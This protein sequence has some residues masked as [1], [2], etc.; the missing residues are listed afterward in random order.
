MNGLPRDYDAWRLSGPH[1]DACPDCDGSGMADCPDCS[2]WSCD[3]CDGSGKI[4]CQTCTTDEPDGDYEYE[5]RRDAA[6]E[7]AQ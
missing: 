6:W 1:D 3:E 5:R 7:D 4:V 2:P